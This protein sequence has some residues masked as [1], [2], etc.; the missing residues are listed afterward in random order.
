MIRRG[1]RT[2]RVASP[3]LATLGFVN[4]HGKPCDNLVVAMKRRQAIQSILSLPAIAA[5]PVSAQDSTPKPA[6]DETAKLAT[7]AAESTTTPTPHF[8]STTQFQTLRH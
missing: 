5:I 4:S 8:F 7:V 2:L 6:S 1:A 3:L